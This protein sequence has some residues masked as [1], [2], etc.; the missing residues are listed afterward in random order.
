M[1][2]EPQ[3]QQSACF[4]NVASDNSQR[5][6]LGAICHLLRVS[7]RSGPHKSA[8]KIVFC[9]RKCLSAVMIVL[10]FQ[11]RL[12][13]IQEGKKQSRGLLSFSALLLL[14]LLRIESV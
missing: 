13:R 7:L 2:A 1:F 11:K 5:M 14:E 3:G 12:P 4:V 8:A 10:T 6:L 9:F